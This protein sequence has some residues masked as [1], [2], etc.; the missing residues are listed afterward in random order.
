MKNSIL[1]NAVIGFSA[2][3]LLLAAVNADAGILFK[4]GNK[5]EPGKVSEDMLV[6]ITQDALPKPGELGSGDY[7]RHLKH[8][9]RERYYDIHVPASYRKDT[10]MPVV[11]N[12]HGGAARPI[13]Q[14]QDS[15]MDDV[16][17]KNGFI[18]VYPAGTSRGFTQMLTWNTLDAKSYATKNNVDDIGF[19]RALLEDIGKL[20][21]VDPKRVYATGYS[22]G[23]ILCY[24][25]ACELSDKIAAIAPV[26]AVLTESPQDRHPGRSMPIIHFHGLLDGHVPY[27]GGVG[28]K[29]VGPDRIPRKSV[30]ET[31]TVWINYN[32]L[33]SVPVRT[34]KLG[35]ANFKEYGSDKDKA[36]IILWTLTDAGHTWPGGKTQMSALGPV[37]QDIKAS[38]VMWDFFKNRRLP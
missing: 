1:R 7:R 34:G 21:N 33:S 28:P 12:F 13:L 38:Q 19:V 2:C 9:G 16:A 17:D 27:N 11:L 26:S 30:D 35:N 32:K 25:L 4:R 5:P 3:L 22:Q 15:G 24:R 10:P 36:P 14:R 8:D 23:G 6:Q 20:F 18:V 31:I 37:N 29:I